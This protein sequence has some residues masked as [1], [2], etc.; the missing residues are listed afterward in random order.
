MQ[1]FARYL[2]EVNLLESA[3]K[4][5]LL[6]Q[7]AD[8]ENEAPGAADEVVPPDPRE[9]VG[10]WAPVVPPGQPA[11]LLGTV[12]GDQ[13]LI[14]LHGWAQTLQWPTAPHH[15]L[16]DDEVTYIELVVHFVAWSGSLIPAA[17]PAG[18]GCYLQADSMEARVLPRTLE[19]A[20]ATLIAASAWLRKQHGLV[21][22][23][24]S[25]TARLYHL[26]TLGLMGGQ[27]GFNRRPLFSEAPDWVPLLRQVCSQRTIAPLERFVAR[28]PAT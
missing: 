13:F 7:Q 19:G 16:Q 25:R 2:V 22:F 17:D 27:A 20:V 24:A 18:S 21:L 15:L 10:D 6:A 9:P 14:T 12:W 1:L 3:L 4:S 5:A 11:F 8:E 28:V 26:Q 23:P